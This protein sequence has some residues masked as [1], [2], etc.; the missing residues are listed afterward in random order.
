MNKPKHKK[1]LDNE[2]TVHITCDVN[3]CTE[4]CILYN[5]GL[6][7]FKG[8]ATVYSVHCIQCNIIAVYCTV[9]YFAMFSMQHIISTFLT[10]KI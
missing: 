2:Y 7:S 3:A 1:I 5:K 4:S 6:Q 10:H 9:P 8:S